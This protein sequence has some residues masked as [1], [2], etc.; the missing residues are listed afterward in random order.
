MSTFFNYKSTNK[1][2]VEWAGIGTTVYGKFED[3][4]GFNTIENE[5]KN[6]PIDVYSYRK[7]HIVKPTQIMTLFLPK[8]KSKE[9]I[10]NIVLKYHHNAKSVN[11][12]NVPKDIDANDFLALSYE[13]NLPDEE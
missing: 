3:Y 4:V 1:T 8:N 10:D 12:T 13:F 9:D 2:K 7:N 6:A 11:L 5:I